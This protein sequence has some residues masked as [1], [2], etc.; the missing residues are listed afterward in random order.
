MNTDYSFSILLRQRHQE[1][2]AEVA[3]DRLARLA[4]RS[5]GRTPWWRRLAPGRLLGP[6][7]A[8][9]LTAHRVAH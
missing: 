4:A 1:L 2:A 7:R 6:G 9:G 3:A 8:H 5:S